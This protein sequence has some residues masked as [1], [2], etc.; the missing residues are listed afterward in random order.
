MR[1]DSEHAI[2]LERTHL[3]R[4]RLGAVDQWDVSDEGEDLNRQLCNALLLAQAVGM[5]ITKTHAVLSRHRKTSRPMQRV[6][7][8]LGKEELLEKHTDYMNGDSSVS[9]VLGLFLHLGTHLRRKR[10]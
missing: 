1:P 5:L 2:I 6:R 3:K 4:K 8:D 10:M 7:K 9:S